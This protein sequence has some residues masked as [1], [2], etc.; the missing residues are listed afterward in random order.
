[1]GK[2]FTIKHVCF[3]ILACLFISKNY[4]QNENYTFK[5]L[6]TD[7]RLPGTSVRNVIQDHKG[8]MWFAIESVGLCKFDGK[9]F[10]VF[11]HNEN[12]TNSLSNNFPLCLAEDSSGFL[13]IGT[14]NGLNRYDRL[15]NTFKRYYNNDSVSHIPNNYVTDLHVDHLNNIW[16][17]TRGGISKYI[18]LQNR[19]YNL[20][21]G[22][23]SYTDGLPGVVS[24]VF[25]DPTGN[26][27]LGSYS[28]GLF[29]IEK[30]INSNHNKG[31]DSL[32]ISD[33]WFP[34]IK[35][36]RGQDN[37]SVQQICSF[38][39]Q[40]LLLGKIDGLFL[41]NTKTA[42]FT[43]YLLKNNRLLNNETVS[44][45][46]KDE[47]GRIWIGYA[48]KGMIF[49]D[50]STN[51]EIYFDAEHFREGGLKSNS[52]RDIYNDK[53]GLIWIGTKFKGIHIYDPR[54]EMLVKNKL[55]NKLSY[56][57]GKAFILS[58]IEDS[59]SNIWI[60]T[61]DEGIYQFNPG[62]DKWINFS[63]GN[64]KNGNY[65]SNN[66]IE[67][68]CEG[69]DGTIWAGT[70]E[71]LHKLNIN[72]ERFKK[73]NNFYIRCL[74]CDN[75]GNIWIGTN[76]SGVFYYDVAN[77]KLGRYPYSVD[78]TFFPRNDVSIKSFFIDQDS[79][80]WVA[81]ENDGLFKYDINED[82]ISRYFSEQI[83]TSDLRGTK[84]TK[85]F[86]DRSGN[87]WAGTVSN[88]LLCYVVRKNRFERVKSGTVTFP[89]SIYNIVQDNQGTMWMGTNKGIL[90][91]NPANGSNAIFDSKYGLNSVI[92]EINA[93]CLTNSNLIF[94]G[95]SDGL[96]VF[97]PEDV[98]VKKYNPEL[99]ITS[100]KAYDAVIAEDIINFSRLVVDFD[101]K[102]VS[103]EFTLTDY[104]SPL[105]AKYAY[106][107][108]HIDKHWIECGN[109]SK[110][111]YTGLPPGE[112]IFKVRT[113]NY[114]VPPLTLMLDVKGPIWHKPYF[115][116]LIIVAIIIAGI[117]IHFT[118]LRMLKKREIKLNQLIDKK[119]H[120]L[121]ELN[122][123]LE[124][125]KSILEEALIKVEESDKLKTAFLANLSHEIRTP[126]NGI[127]G[128]AELLRNSELETDQQQKYIS[129]IQRSSERMLR[130]I[131]DLV[132]ISKIES[133]QIHVLPEKNN[134]IHI[135]D[136]VYDFFKQGA[137]NKNVELIKEITLKD[138]NAV[139][140]CDKTRIVQVITN[141]VSNAIKF[142]PNGAVVLGCRR[143]DN[144]IEIFVRDNG[145]GIPDSK[146]DVIFERFMQIEDDKYRFNEG[147]GLGL[148]I[149]K[150]LVEKHGGEIWVD[151]ELGK[152]S[153]FY[154]TLPINNYEGE[155]LEQVNK[156]SK[157]QVDY[158]IFTG[159][160]V[161]V[162]EDDE[163]SWILLREIL[164]KEN[165]E[166]SY[167]K[168]G[169]EAVDKIA[170]K[171]FP[172]IILMDIKM[173]GLN[174]LEAARQIK[175]LNQN[176]PII[177]QTAFLQGLGIKESK[178]PYVDDYL[179]KPIDN[180]ELLD[181]IYK[182]LI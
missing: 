11:E 57:I 54:Q 59:N 125:N 30:D 176:I 109:N 88:D 112:Y 78:T 90:R 44:A 76:S 164:A 51:N 145:I 166:V 171:H 82:R 3:F 83:D 26:I 81:T 116:I 46:L 2:C 52:I 146:K 14:A 106:M 10:T 100:V 102:F 127:L 31:I 182:Y 29:L 167:A 147:S 158:D 24:D 6:S 50:L 132:D 128:F 42:T 93:L 23:D 9:N 110:A 141:L 114:D 148:T 136:E 16:V 37:Y 179:S 115:I 85:L 40:N 94:S 98:H 32:K 111:S 122:Q 149:S 173:P 41:F 96:N 79:V 104:I 19:F 34:I 64:Y 63:S 113:L 13:W 66:R 124:E 21:I 107:L 178:Y 140:F 60:G 43:K 150:A 67:C 144:V 92:T 143:D 130:I 61:K 177:L 180:T 38:N 73:L 65:I 133:N 77:N 20:L 129:I 154:F 152:G 169:Q 8:L 62:N 47:D 89:H 91:Y 71:G 36:S 45:L 175:K 165:M 1:M 119:T 70:K 163:H 174:G 123:F 72:D 95:G 134:I 135:I 172:D 161:M 157:P 33:H 15:S 18:P 39:E 7:N 170:N 121:L 120:D 28:S 69:L 68:M 126:M 99:L 105:K 80:L 108:E 58:I 160:R 168:D 153:T 138:K 55:N 156:E 142:S 137:V 86:K 4:A 49:L 131:H 139:L 118:R 101:K 48:N 22:E 162:V 25:E 75:N 117:I 12:D 97:S 155:R 17:A 35:N 103:I 151:S 27:W 5:N 74:A 56:K 84:V 159:K 53:N 87:L 181:I